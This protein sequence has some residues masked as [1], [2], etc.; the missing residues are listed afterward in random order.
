MNNQ[1]LITTALEKMLKLHEDTHKS[2]TLLRGIT[3]GL[4]V[5]IE[6]LEK[7]IESFEST[8]PQS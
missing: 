6:L 4:Q 3:L 8:S 7:K 1:E 5:K 2:L